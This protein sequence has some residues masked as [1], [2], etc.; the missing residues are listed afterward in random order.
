MGSS[1]V[2]APSS[3]P[4]TFLNVPP[5]V[6]LR[7]TY[8]SSTSGLSFPVSQVFVI[9]VGGGG[10]GSIGGGGGGAGACLMGWI[11]SP[12]AV[13]IGAGGTGGANGGATIVGN[14]YAMGGNAGMYSATTPKAGI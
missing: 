12:T 14:I 3:A 5:G 13:T 9:V 7:N 10:S 1:T 6:S 2:P 4:T 11:S 8:T